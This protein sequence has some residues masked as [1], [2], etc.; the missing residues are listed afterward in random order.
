MTTT[1]AIA[2]LLALH[3]G[4]VDGPPLIRS[5]RSGR[6][7]DP[8]TW[9]GGAVPDEGDRVQI[10][11]GHTVH[12]D[13]DSDRTIRSIHV[14]GTLEFARDRDTRLDVGLIKIQA[15]DDAS[16]NG[17]DCDAHSAGDHAGH[18]RPALLVGLPHEPIPAGT[19]ATIRLKFVDGMDPETC[20]AIVCCGGRMEFHGAPMPRTWTKLARE[21][22]RNEAV[23]LLPREDVEG[24]NP[25]DRVILTGTAR[26]FGYKDTR[27]T[28]VAERPATEE[29][30]IREFKPYGDD[31]VRLVLD[32]PLE[33]DHRAQGD[34]RG[35][36]ANLSRNVVVES[37]EPGGVRG[38]TMYH[39]GSRGSISYAEF[40]HLGKRGVLGKYSL[41]FHLVGESMRGSS[42]IGASIWDS[43]NRWITVHGTSYL[44]VRDCVGYRSIGHGFFLED[45]TE[46]RNV[47]DHNLAVMA[48]RGEPLPD[49]V[50][51]F[52]GNL[53]S[54]FWWAN[55]LNTFTDNVAA[56]CDQDGFRFE[57]VA[58]EQFDP[59]R[60]VLQPDGSRRPVDLRTLPFIRFEGNE[61]HCQ[62]FFGLNLGGFTSGVVPPD[63]APKE[64]VI[65]DVDGIGPDERHPFLIRDFRA[66]DTH[67]AF[68]A[69]SPCVRAEGLDLYDSEYALWRCVIDRHE[70]ADLKI[71]RITTMGMFFPRPG[72]ATPADGIVNLDPVDD[73][74]P[75][76][77]I[78]HVLPAGS[79]S[80]VLVRGTA[81]DDDA[82]R[83]VVVN[84]REAIAL[85]PNFAEWQV[86]LDAD[87][88][89]AE[90]IAR[91]EDVAGNVEQ[92]P[93]I[94]RPTPR[95]TG[96]DRLPLPT[97][98][99][100]DR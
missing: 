62:R 66:W 87:P 3:L 51:P 53:G 20:P 100:A 26:Q 75:T 92:T 5:A 27:T 52:D 15:G 9:E 18:D 71:G 58:S 36:V 49:Q 81:S 60:P 38:H 17:F 16:E 6:W 2:L 64:F 10:R 76:T 31:L 63:S 22:Y 70:Y 54:G 86:E 68:H 24:W 80:R 99:T 84:G 47:F 77:V 93:H 88:A 78:T 97:S 33:H 4:P 37:A 96:T 41:H 14:A 30:T 21:A 43:E 45:G 79:A 32:R 89:G 61:A 65:E 82:I 25:G 85:R 40:R 28:S 12:Y 11:G 90:L 8:A 69:G 95:S 50:L 7:S 39:R 34:Y 74:P 44:V 57:V 83:R 94:L 72:R 42:V 1:T 98:P 73:L 55:S 91:S 19:T 29:R 13:R 23:V 67:W 35:E 59:V 46:T 48:L 56:E